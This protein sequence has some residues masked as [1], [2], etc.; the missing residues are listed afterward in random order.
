MTRTALIRN[1]LAEFR[2]AP[3]GRALKR[4]SK[5]RS[6]GWLQIYYKNTKTLK[7]LLTCGKIK[8]ERKDG[9]TP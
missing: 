2:C 4:L 1:G 3:Y 9:E 5:Q 7:N 6:K 8:S